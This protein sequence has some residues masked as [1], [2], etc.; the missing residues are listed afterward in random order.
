MNIVIQLQALQ[1]GGLPVFVVGDAT[2]SYEG[3]NTYNT[4]S[5]EGSKKE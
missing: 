3:G 2:L 4:I 1:I 5:K